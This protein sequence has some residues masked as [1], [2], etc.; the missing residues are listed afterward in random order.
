ML[1]LEHLQCFYLPAHWGRITVST[2]ELR[3]SHSILTYFSVGNAALVA[4]FFSFF[5]GT[6]QTGITS[7]FDVFSGGFG[8][9]SSG[10]EAGGM[11]HGTGSW[12]GGR[13]AGITAGWLGGTWIAACR[14]A[15]GTESREMIWSSFFDSD[16]WF[17]KTCTCLL[18]IVSASG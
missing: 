7:S 17:C 13:L 10:I 8:D 5:C 6:W 18:A 11:V 1:Y 12:I 2:D 15:T 9:S 16:S 3:S 14:F 4:L